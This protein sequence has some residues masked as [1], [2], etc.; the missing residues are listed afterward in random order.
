MIDLKM[1]C[2]ENIKYI[3]I[4]FFGGGRSHVRK[5]IYIYIYI[6]IYILI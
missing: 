6:Y 3:A 4:K 1:R 5:L 2:V